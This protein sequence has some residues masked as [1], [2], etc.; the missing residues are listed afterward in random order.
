MNFEWD[1][2]DIYIGRKRSGEFVGRKERACGVYSKDVFVKGCMIVVRERGSAVTL[3][4]VRIYYCVY[5]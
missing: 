4:K 5:S 2:I 3:N 1:S